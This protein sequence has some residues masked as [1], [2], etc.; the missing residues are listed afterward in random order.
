[1]PD[2][3][4]A[5]IPIDRIDIDPTVQ[6]RGGNHE[7]TIQRYMA[8]WDKLPRVDVFDLTQPGEPPRA[9]DL[10]LA[11]GFHR[12]ATAIRLGLEEID[13]VVHRGTRAD[14]LEFAVIA[15]TKNADP[16]TPE[17]RDAGIRRI[18][19]LHPDWTLRTVAEAM[20]VTHL[21]VKRVEDADA[22]K[23]EVVAPVTRVTDSHYA[24]VAGAP[25]K[26]WEPLVKAADQR[27]WTR[28]ETRLA[29]RNL[30]DERVPEEH[31]EAIR[32]GSADPVT[33]GQD[34]EMGIPMDRVGRTLREAERSD[35]HLALQRV[36]GALA[37]LRVVF[38]AEQMVA[39]MSPERRRQL[40]DEV[41]RV[42]IPFLEDIA[43]AAEKGRTLE[44][45]K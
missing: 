1:M 31:K 19:Q 15:N 45:V 34:G 38:D 2:T 11:D 4:H 40:A 14:A 28:D 37:N 24:E 23:R 25:Q 27:G 30:K 8:A 44:A 13:V 10:L 26:D 36:L 5:T 32:S 20:S 21:T 43:A 7:Q 41:R 22:V 12:V 6:I 18:R 33:V 16:L 42:Y 17:E 35:A 29:V 9:K 3:T 39:T